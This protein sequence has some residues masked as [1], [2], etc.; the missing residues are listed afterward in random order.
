MDITTPLDPD[1][2]FHGMR[3][4]EEISRLSEYE[5]SLL[6]PKDDLDLNKVLGKK[7]SVKLALPDDSPREFNGYVTRISQG[8]RYGRYNRYEA[9]VRPWLWFLTRTTDCRIF[10]EMTVPDIVKK[11]FLDH[12][13]AEFSFELTGSY[14]TLTYCVQYRET[15][16][17]FISRLL[18]HEGIYYYFRHTGGQNMLVVTDSYSGHEAFPNY[19]ELPINITNRITR[20]DFEQITSWDFSRRVEPGVYTHD[21]YDLERPTVE[22]QTQKTTA[23]QYENSDYEVYDY[24]GLYVKAPVG[25]Q[26]A[27]VRIEEYGT[28]FETVEGA[29]NARGVSVGYL[30]KTNG[31]P[32]QDQ[33]DEYL[34][35]A[36]SYDLEYSDYE[37]VP[38]RGG[39]N[40][41]CNFTAMASRQQFRP[42]RLTP[43]PFMQ[44]P[45]TARVVGPSGE[46]IHTDK[47]GRIKVQFHWD[48]YGKGDENSSCWIRVSQ[49]WA[50]KGWGSVV[51]PRIDQ[52]V[53][54]A[55][56]EGDP[57]QPIVTGCV[58]NGENT[59]PY[60][61]PGSG[62]VSGLK[63]NTHKGKGMNEMT[64]N[65]TAGKE[66]ITI[67]AQ[68]DMGTT[69][70]HD[71]TNTVNNDFTETIKNNASITI[72]QGKFSHDVAA[73]VAK[74]H[75]KGAL[76]EVYEDT[77]KTTVTNDI[78]IK[79]TA[80][81]ITIS[82]DSQHIYVHAANSIQLHTGSS[83]LWMSSD[84]NISLTGVNITISG[85]SNVTT[86]GGT[87]HSEA[88]SEHQTKGAIVISEGSATNTVKGG[89]VM[90][91]P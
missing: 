67:H 63:S 80:G 29:T 70:Q 27:A 4:R 5:V 34:I 79:S 60:G 73:N 6:S 57:D 44:G 25:E 77:Q 82:S 32:R 75:V 23:R 84:G 41:S 16:F 71:Q 74:Y 46:E 78:E 14:P 65:D 13:T 64:M 12:P 58:Y 22:L 68:Y 72:T 56:L 61:L 49:T 76:D 83:A 11:V 2:L 30:L 54:V 37:A 48:R 1:L 81:A 66:K 31:H 52:E 19:K 91:N 88:V 90:L 38:D 86:K 7:V 28:E 15:D 26:Y 21:H 10:Q 24:P 53:I 85:D 69:V 87:V 3:A 33:N 62:V 36:A 47:F 9:T 17:N 43:K 8:S 45:Q 42:R 18:E 55:F 20:P 50:G 39:A 40:Y 35:V 59:P 89:M 51:I